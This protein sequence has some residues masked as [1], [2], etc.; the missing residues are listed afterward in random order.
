MCENGSIAPYLAPHSYGEAEKRVPIVETASEWCHS[1][2]ITL[3][4]Q[5]LAAFVMLR[6]WSRLDGNASSRFATVHRLAHGRPG[7]DADQLT[8]QPTTIVSGIRSRKRWGCGWP[9]TLG[10]FSRIQTAHACPNELWLSP[11]EI[12]TLPTS[13]AVSPHVMGPESTRR[14]A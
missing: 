3:A 9:V 4:S 10:V 14:T 2:F 11:W 8:C 7:K 13:E 1:L 5:G 6:G 12:W